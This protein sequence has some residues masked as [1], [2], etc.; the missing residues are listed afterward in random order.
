MFIVCEEKNNQIFFTGQ[1]LAF[2]NQMKYD[3]D[4]SYAC[5]SRGMLKAYDE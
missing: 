3:F 2:L 4:F 5:G 1:L